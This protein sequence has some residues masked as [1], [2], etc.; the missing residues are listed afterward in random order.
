MGGVVSKGGALSKSSYG[1]ECGSKCKVV[2]ENN[3]HVMCNEA[4]SFGFC[5][6]SVAKPLVEIN[7]GED[8]SD[9]RLK[10]SSKNQRKAGT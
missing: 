6:Q 9:E 4:C 8:L 1:R 3:S 7:R 2:K 10:K 5:S